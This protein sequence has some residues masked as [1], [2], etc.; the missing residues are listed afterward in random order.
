MGMM[1]T[2]V[3]SELRAHVSERLRNPLL[4]PFT[5]GWLIFNWRLVAVLLFSEKPVEERIADIDASYLS[6]TDLLWIPLAFALGFALLIPWVSWGIQYV[7][8]GANLRRRKHRLKL[9]TEYLEASVERAEA[10]A[11][12]NRILARDE[13]TRRQQEEIATIKQQLD[14]QRE[15]AQARIAAAEAELQQKRQEYEKLSETDD[16]SAA[17]QREEI[18]R[19]RAEVEEEQRRARAET[20]RAQRDLAQKQKEL[21]ARLENNDSRSLQVSDSELKELLET[22]RFRLFHNPSVGPERAKTITFA[23]DGNV[24]EGRNKNEHRWRVSNSRLELL[25]ADGKVHSRFYFM[26]ESRIF[27]HT[28]D[29]DTRSARGQYIIPEANNLPKE[30]VSR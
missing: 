24:L 11:T 21:E 8:E 18:D 14:E 10:Q 23:P 16:R 5:V 7:Q 4:G 12:L 13:I 3:L 20:E 6:F 26:P 30:T 9:D 1:I 27:L 22:G 19:L 17:A 2:E 25:Q 29:S 15:S 28:G